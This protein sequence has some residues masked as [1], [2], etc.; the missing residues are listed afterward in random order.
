MAWCHQATSHYLIQCWPSFM[1]PYGVTRPQWVNHL[2]VEVLSGNT[3]VYFHFISFLVDELAQDVEILPHIQYHGCWWP[4]DSKNQGI[5][6]YGVTLFSQEYWFQYQ[7]HKIWPI[8][9]WEIWIKFQL[10]IFKLILQIDDCGIYC[11]IALSWM[12]LNLTDNKSTLVQVM[13][14]CH[15][16]TS[17]YLCKCWPKSMSPYVASFTNMV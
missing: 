11:D 2:N 10:V 7:H 8:V 17:H 13:A 12:S 1:S 15:Q 16:A 4:G 3:Q 5:S 14:W 6:S 9:P